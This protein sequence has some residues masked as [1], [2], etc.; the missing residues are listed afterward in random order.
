MAIDVQIGSGE[1]EEVPVEEPKPIQAKVK[2]NARK[3]L[4]GNLAIFDHMDVDIVVIPKKYKILVMPKN[5]LSDEVYD[6]QSRLFEFLV[7]KGVVLPESVR[8][9]RIYG[10][11]E[12]KYPPTNEEGI[13][14][15]QAAI[16]TINKFIEEEKPFF[17][18]QKKMELEHEEEMLDPGPEEST[19]LGEVPHEA[20]KGSV[21]SY[22]N[23]YSTFRGY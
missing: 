21:P 2:L 9:G 22:I 6:T 11:L 16:F 15:S 1:E 7:K 3:T 14:T 20:S 5:E 17:M 10:S 19:E 13:D 4:D 12:G 18:W 8:G 23:D